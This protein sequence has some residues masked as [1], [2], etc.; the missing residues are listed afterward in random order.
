MNILSLAYLGNVQWFSKLLSGPCIIDIHEHYVKQSYRTRCDILTSNGITPLVVN[1]IKGS[2]FNKLTVKETRIDY[3]KRWQHQHYQTLVSA[4]R[5]SPYFDYYFDLLE[6]FFTKKFEFLTD[7]N[8]G[9]LQTVLKITGQ[10]PDVRL[11]EKYID[12]EASEEMEGAEKSDWEDFRDAISPKPRL[13]RPDP[14]FEPQAY[15]QV[16]S[17]RMP[18]AANLSIVDLL[19][20][21]GPNAV[22]II[23]KSVI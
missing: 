19:F 23:K 17:D 18:F 6:P 11:S 10:N 21:E 2:N 9:L 7:L 4:Y 15:W 20:C 8:L 13:A 16:F 22:E 12:L 1:T 3:S 5:S 14:R